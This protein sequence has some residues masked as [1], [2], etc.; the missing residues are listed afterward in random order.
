MRKLKSA[1]AN[2]IENTASMSPDERENH[3][4]SLSPAI[5]AK[6]LKLL[7]SKNH[8]KNEESFKAVKNLFLRRGSCVIVSG[9]ATASNCEEV[10][11]IPLTSRLTIKGILMKNNSYLE[12]QEGNVLRNYL[13]QAKNLLNLRTRMS[14]SDY[15]SFLN[16][17]GFKKQ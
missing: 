14:P 8:K 10:L 12:C 11:K 3:V 5:A 4:S 13:I 6:L 15:R 7:E 16:E 17:C 2:W 9:L 1:F